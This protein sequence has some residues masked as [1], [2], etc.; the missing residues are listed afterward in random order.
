MQKWLK[1]LVEKDVR[2]GESVYFWKDVS[3]DKVSLK[4]KFPE[5]Y[6]ISYH[7]EASV[8][9]IFV[10]GEWKLDF[11]RNLNQQRQDKLIV[12]R[13]MI[14]SY[15]L[16]GGGGGKDQVVWHHNKKKSFT[17]KLVYIILTF[18]GVIDAER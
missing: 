2:N 14:N 18:R 10:K 9:D 17:T 11:R 15:Q 5:L 12:L 16:D 1:K 6:E 3:C 4:V 7:Q 13:M 8:S